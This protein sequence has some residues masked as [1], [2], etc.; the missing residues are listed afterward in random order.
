VRALVIPVEGPL[1]EVDLERGDGASLAQLQGLVGG[2]IEAVPL[3]GFIPGA[4]RATGYV[5][6][7]GKLVGAPANMRATDFMVPGVGLFWGDYIAGPLVLCGFDPRTGR[8]ADLPE[9][10]GRRA[11]LIEREASG[12]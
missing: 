2:A 10:V 4:D 8:H 1:F 3:P 5:H 11:R 7:E 12:A 9:D 6:D